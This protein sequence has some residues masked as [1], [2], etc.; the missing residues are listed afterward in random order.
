MVNAISCSFR[1]YFCDKKK[2]TFR[3]KD[4]FFFFFFDLWGSFTKFLG[5]MHYAN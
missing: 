5:L 2:K 1:I 4:V 3:A